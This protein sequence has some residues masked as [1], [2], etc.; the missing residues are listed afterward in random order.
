MNTAKRIKKIQAG[1]RRKKIDALLVTQPNNRRYLS[2]YTASDH[3]IGESSG[4]ILVPARKKPLLLTDF[5][6]Q[7][8]AE[9]EVKNMDVLLYPRGRIALLKELLLCLCL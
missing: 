3:D 9:Q 5:R 4:V 7:I 1:L 6:F 2:G 8:Q